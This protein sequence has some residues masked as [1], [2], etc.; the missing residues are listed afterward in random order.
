MAVEVKINGNETEQELKIKKMVS[1]FLKSGSVYASNNLQP[2]AK[3]YI[4][5]IMKSKYWA[6]ISSNINKLS[7]EFMAQ[8]NKLNDEDKDLN[9]IMQITNYKKM[10][11]A[12]SKE[13]LKEAEEETKR[14]EEELKKASF[15][16]KKAERKA[17]E[18]KNEVVEK[19]E[20]IEDNYDA[21]FSIINLIK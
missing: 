9:G 13:I 16:P 12:F 20:N 6:E 21:F 7:E 3:G 4:K 8:Q 2:E 10:I 11:A 17:V 5:K 15:N 1:A 14:A 19:E 18:I